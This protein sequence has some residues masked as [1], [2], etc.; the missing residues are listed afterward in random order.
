MLS[1]RPGRR[2]QTGSVTV[3]FVVIFPILLLLFFG[4]ID[5]G[6]TYNSYMRLTS[7]SLAG[8]Q[9][10]SVSGNSTDLSGMQT[11]ATNAADGLVGFSVAASKY[12]A[13]SPGGAS[14]SCSASCT[15]YGTPVAY[16]MVAASA[17]APS[18]FKYGTL[19]MIYPLKSTVILRVQ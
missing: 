10:G 6:W 12:C 3:E 7:A 11:A 16:V 8:A 4:V 5:F 18:L 19:G 13:C 14:V 17:S 9:Y 1:S 2:S 15:G